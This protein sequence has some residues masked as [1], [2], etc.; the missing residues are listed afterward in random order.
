MRNPV[1]VSG[2]LVLLG[3][4]ARAQLQP[5]HRVDLSTPARIHASQLSTEAANALARADYPLALSITEQGL[6]VDPN[7][8][9]LHYNKGVALFGMQRLDEAVAELDLAEQKF[10]PD[11]VWGRS[12]AIY[13]R[14]IKLQQA[15]RCREASANFQQYA[16]LVRPYDGAAAALAMRYDATGC[17]TVKPSVAERPAP[18]LERQPVGGRARPKACPPQKTPGVPNQ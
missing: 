4:A 7:D 16:R 1:I 18:A 5:L 12:V 15:G 17:P 13:Q 10:T 3:G 2:L 6:K 14:A 9:W 8:P 11:D